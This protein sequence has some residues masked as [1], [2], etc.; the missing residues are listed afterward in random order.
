[1][2]FVWLI[3]LS[4]IVY[5]SPT[6]KIH[7]SV[8]GPLGRSHVLALVN[9]IA[10]NMKCIYLFR[11]VF[12]FLQINTW[13]KFLDHMLAL[14]LIFWGTSI[15]F[16]TVAVPVYIHTNS[17]CIR[18]RILLYPHQCLLLLV[19]LV[20]AVL[21]GVRWYF[22]VVLIAF[23]WWLFPSFLLHVIIWLV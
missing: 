16:P 7:S 13:M 20:K 12:C 8:G 11:L 18:V 22:I 2:V 21:T 6:L 23:P 9:N 10:V 3:S 1:M 4:V 5:L 17:E 15:L 14:F 19:C